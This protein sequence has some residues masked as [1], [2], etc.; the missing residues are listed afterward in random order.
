MKNRTLTSGSTSL[1]SA[2]SSS[3]PSRVRVSASEIVTYA[4]VVNAFFVALELFTALY[5]GIP[6]HVEHFAYLYVGLHGHG[7]LAPWMWTSLSLA[8][9]S[10][11]LLLVPALRRNRTVLVVAC[12]AVIAALWIEKGLGMVV[13]GFVPSPLGHVNEYW[14]TGPE[15]RIALGIYALGGLLLAGLYK[16]AIAVREELEVPAAPEQPTVRDAR[17]ELKVA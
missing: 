4:M 2:S 10:L 6:E 17:K 16:I 1:L 8:A 3:Q 11:V 14:P 12:V 7:V 5:S 13:T 9:L 15:V